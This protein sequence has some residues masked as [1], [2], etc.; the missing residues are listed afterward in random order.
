[1][2]ATLLGAKWWGQGWHCG[3]PHLCGAEIHVCSGDHTAVPRLQ[4]TQ[5]KTSGEACDRGDGHTTPHFTTYLFDNCSDLGPIIVYMC[6]CS[7]VYLF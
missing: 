4:V 7:S 3:E 2:S 5:P 1:M 6:V